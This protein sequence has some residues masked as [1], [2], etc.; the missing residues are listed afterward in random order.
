MQSEHCI[1][2]LKMQSLHYKNNILCNEY[3]AQLSNVKFMFYK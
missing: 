2:K 3:I 1:I